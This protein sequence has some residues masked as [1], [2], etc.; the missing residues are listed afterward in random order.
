MSRRLFRSLTQ[1]LLALVSV[2]QIGSFVCAA[3]NAGKPL[4]CTELA[5][6]IDVEIGK[7]L[8]AKKIPVSPRS[9]DAEFLR[10]VSLDVSGVIPTAERAQAFLDGKEADKRQRVIEELLAST[11]HARMMTD[12][13]RQLLV[14][15]T[16]QARGSNQIPLIRW[17]NK[18]FTQNKPWHKMTHELL[19]ARGFQE[20]N[21]AVTFYVVHESID[22]LADRVSKVFLGVQ[23]QC[24]Q[25]HNHPFE[26]WK[27]KEYWAFA[28]FFGK[29]GRLYARKDGV[30]HAGADEK[31]KKV[32]M[33]P[34]SAKKEPLQFLRGKQPTIAPD[35]RYLPVLADWITSAD[36]PYFAK[37]MVNRLWFHFFGRGLVNPVDGMHTGNPAAYPELFDLLARQFVASEFD[38]RHLIRS[39]CL[40]ETYQRSSIPLESNKNDHEFY[41]RSVVRV[42][43]PYHLC[44]SWDLVFS[45][46]NDKQKQPAIADA[47]LLLQAER[48]LHG[49]RDS[50]ASYFEPEEGTSPLEYRAGIPQALRL[51]NGRDYHGIA[52]AARVIQSQTRSNAAAV[53]RLFLTALTRRPDACE[54]GRFVTYLEQNK[55]NYQ[56]HFD[57]LWALLNSSEFFTNH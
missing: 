17:L 24:A 18:S 2:W 34:D 7:K 9:D 25:C 30:E 50:F 45:V 32:L 26:D 54:S 36:N 48:Q 23:L 28:G 4:S 33:L 21:P 56:A 22:M 53:D 5:K 3:E 8:E 6:R 29:V 16:A 42:M 43:K 1:S 52:R 14:P 27:R 13:W 41:S 35:Q 40:S 20:E 38:A 31:V 49:R 51:M 11:E 39:I 37:A 44:D 19:T 46:G 15:E 55:N 10:R 47:K 57:V 12:L